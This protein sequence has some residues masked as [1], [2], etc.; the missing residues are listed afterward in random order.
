MN[1]S[2]E[3]IPS[4][5]F[6]ATASERSGRRMPL[7]RTL[8][9]NVFR[10]LTRILTISDEDKHRFKQFGV[11]AQQMIVAGDTRFD[12]VLARR[13]PLEQSGEM[14]LPER[15]RTSIAD[16]G[17]LVFVVGSSWES[18]EAIYVDTIKKKYRAKR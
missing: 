6:A 1:Y 17:T 9:R 8:Y 7:V 14:I 10:S 2:D 5:L 12:Q 16:R 18:D 13:I 3:K 4:I 11:D 15:I